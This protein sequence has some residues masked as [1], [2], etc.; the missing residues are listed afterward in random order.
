MKAN[1]NKKKYLVTERF[2]YDRSNF[3]RTNEKQATSMIALIQQMKEENALE[4]E[5]S[6]IKFEIIKI[7]TI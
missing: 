3:Y 7:E 1:S 2:V 4:E 5:K 6:G